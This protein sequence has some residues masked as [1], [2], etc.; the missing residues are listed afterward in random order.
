MKK[1]TILFCF[2]ALWLSAPL[3]RSQEKANQPA[4]AS[5][6]GDPIHTASA[7]YPK[8]ARKQKLE[9]PVALH[10][11]VATDGS[12]K[13]VVVVSGDSRLTDAAVEAVRQ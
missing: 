12:V 7:K 9:G 5:A 4:S 3:V 13:D 1:L 2:G 6:P 11:T 10:V 8:K